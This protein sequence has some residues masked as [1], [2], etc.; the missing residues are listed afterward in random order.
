MVALLQRELVELPITLPQDQTVFV[1]LG[2]DDEA[3]WLKKTE[4]LRQQGG[5]ALALTHPDY[6]DVGDSLRA[7][8]RLLAQYESDTTVL[9][10]AARGG[11]RLVAATRGL[12]PRAPQ[13]RVARRRTRRSRRCGVVRRSADEL[14]LIGP[15]RV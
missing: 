9:E 11:Q 12:A 6:L 7:Y 4:L 10:G 1:I 2:H 14:K 8:D 3:L 15:C 5:M 13:R